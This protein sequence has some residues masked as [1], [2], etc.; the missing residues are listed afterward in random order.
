MNQQLGPYTLV[1]K[2]GE[3]GMA[4]VFKA[5]KTGPEGFEK[6]VALKRILPPFHDRADMIN[7]FL[8]EAKLHAQ[9]THPKLIHLIDFFQHEKS[10]VLVMEYFQSKN[11]SQLVQQ[12]H[13]KGIEIPWQAVVYVATE[14]LE[15]LDY[16]HKKK[17]L[18]GPLNIVHRDVSPQNILISQDGWV[19]LAD[20]G[21]ALA[22]VDRD[23]TES[24][25]LKGKVKY[26]SPEQIQEKKADHR[27]D[28][29]SMGIVLYD[30]ICK[31]HPFYAKVEFEVLQNISSGIFQDSAELAPHVPEAV[32]ECIRTALRASNMDR[33]QEASHMRLDLLKAQDT[34]WLNHGAEL[35]KQWLQKIHSEDL[36]HNE[37]PLSKTKVLASTPAPSGSSAKKG[38]AIGLTVICIALVAR[39]FSEE[40]ETTPKLPSPPVATTP[41]SATSKMA[42]LRLSGTDGSSV[43][44][45]GKKIGTLPMPNHSIVPGSYVVLIISASKKTTL[46][47]IHPR[48]GDIIDA[49]EEP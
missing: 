27:S 14:V 7:M 30:L 39:L 4:E 24:K 47:R 45:N 18:Q 48:A 49:R 8:W 15:A 38:W 21:I 22:N 11:L 43:F 32:H 33:F 31:R 41:T 9:L 10:F 2:L 37:T 46:V 19:K 13:K 16:A 26:L 25:V 44:I 12:A 20:F 6:P 42:T 1:A 40:A 3:G 29:F 35:F 23:K 17:N 34:A 5:I 28:I 36:F